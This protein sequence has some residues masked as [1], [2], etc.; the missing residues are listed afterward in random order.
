MTMLDFYLLSIVG[1]V[2]IGGLFAFRLA[3]KVYLNAA[4]DAHC[5]RVMSFDKERAG[6]P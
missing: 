6:H 3:R 5:Q 2:L 1:F 4:M